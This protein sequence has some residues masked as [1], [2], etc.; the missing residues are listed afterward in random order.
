MLLYTSF[1]YISCC[2]DSL[3]AEDI[4]KLDMIKKVVLLAERTLERRKARVN[5][6]LQWVSEVGIS[7]KVLEDSGIAY[8]CFVMQINLFLKPNILK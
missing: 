6:Y 2:L 4:I 3:T 8:A 5:K 7:K 1:Y